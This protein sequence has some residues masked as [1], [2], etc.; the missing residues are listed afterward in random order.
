MSAPISPA[1][2]SP[3]VLEAAGLEVRRGGSLVLSAPRLEVGRGETLAV[4]GPNGAGK[5]TLLLV[6]ALLLKPT[7]GWVRVAGELAT[8]ANALRLR[9]RMA[10]VFQEPL[11]LDTSVER[12][13]ATGLELRG[14]PR[15]ER[16]ARV[17]KWLE[18]FGI[19]HL[20]KRPA[21]TLSGGEA[22]RVSLARAFALEPEVLLLDEPFS[23]L[24]APTRAALTADLS[25][26]LQ[27]TATTTVL[28]T[29]DRD[30]AL[31]LGDRVAVLIGGELRQVGPPGEVFGA[32]VDAEV[33]GFVGVETIVPGI[34]TAQDEGLARVSLGGHAAE[35]VSDLPAGTAVYVCLRP[36]DVTL[37]TVPDREASAGRT[38]ARNRFAGRVSGLGPWRGQIRVTVDCGFTL[39]AAV[40]RRSAAE[41]ELGVGTPV[42][43]TFK[44]TSA[45]L[46]SRADSAGA[47]AIPSGARSAGAGRVGVQ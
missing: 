8:S 11:L 2:I 42:V 31:A 1:P 33:A 28:V 19:A 16:D 12:N 27:A 47:G 46:I 14:T 29:H 15:K 10:V 24:D 44:A 5:S 32:P 25:A 6:L 7:A 40:T 36:E 26:A 21:R 30:E 45:H 41:L 37:Q 34:V 4:M 23:A 38:S 9:R 13:V 17:A 20:A 22:Q 18:A 39:V 35:V 3:V 43:A